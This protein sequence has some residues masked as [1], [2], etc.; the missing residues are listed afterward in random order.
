[1][2]LCRYSGLLEHVG[3]IPCDIEPFGGGGNIRKPNRLC[4]SLCEHIKTYELIVAEDMDIVI[5]IWGSF[6]PSVY[7]GFDPDPKL[8]RLYWTMV[9][10]INPIH[11]RL[12]L[13]SLRTWSGTFLP[14]L[15][16]QGFL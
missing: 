14:M 2:F 4:V 1:M 6:I 11:L 8:I 13:S 5:L 12:R 16:C 15:A 9:R 3:Y 7:Y 10:T